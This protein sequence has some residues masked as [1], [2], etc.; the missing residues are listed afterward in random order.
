MRSPGL[1][2]VKLP[3]TNRAVALPAKVEARRL[4]A[5]CGASK[6]FGLSVRKRRKTK[7]AGD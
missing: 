7:A 4:L 6:L 3:L 5:Q 1:D 2:P